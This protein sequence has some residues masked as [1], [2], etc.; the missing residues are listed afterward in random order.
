[1]HSANKITRK[2][3]AKIVL[4]PMAFLL[5]HKVADICEL[6]IEVMDRSHTEFSYLNSGCK[7][8]VIIAAAEKVGVRKYDHVMPP[9]R[10]IPS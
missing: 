6:R 5:L 3:E 10:E 8:S 4:E 7:L 9:H 2:R 1:M